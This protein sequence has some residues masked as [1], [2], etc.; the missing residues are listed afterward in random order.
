MALR[1]TKSQKVGAEDASRKREMWPEV[2][3]AP[4]WKAFS[5]WPG[6]SHSDNQMAI[7]VGSLAARNAVDMLEP[8]TIP[9]EGG[10]RSPIVPFSAQRSNSEPAGRDMVRQAGA[11]FWG[12]REGT[13]ARSHVSDAPSHT[14]QHRAKG[15]PVTGAG[16]RL[17]DRVR[18]LRAREIAAKEIPKLDLAVISHAEP[19]KGFARLR[20]ARLMV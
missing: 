15:L 12:L 8:Q 20:P 10:S 11:A 9:Q 5:T 1:K 14:H 4:A 6:R 7:G 13:P 18:E 17:L 2:L 19:V 3:Q 16:A